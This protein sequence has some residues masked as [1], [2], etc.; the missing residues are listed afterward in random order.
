M[1]KLGML[2]LL[3]VF[4]VSVIGCGDKTKTEEKKTEAA[5][6]QQVA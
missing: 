2:L 1:K 5:S 6:V 4:S 3:A